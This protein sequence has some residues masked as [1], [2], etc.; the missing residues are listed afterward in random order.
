[1][2]AALFCF[3]GAAIA[4]AEEPTN[5][6]AKAQGSVASDVQSGFDIISSIDNAVQEKND[7]TIKV[8]NVNA[9]SAVLNW[10][11]SDLCISYR[12]CRFNIIQNKWED[13]LSTPKNELKLTNLKENTNYKYCVM[14]AATGE[15]LGVTEF[16]TGLSKPTIAV[17]ERD[18]DSVKLSVGKV[19]KGAKV[20]L[21]RKTKGKKYKKIATLSSKKKTYTDKKLKGA[22]TYYYKAKTT[23]T[24]K[25]NGKSVTKKSAYSKEKKAKTL[26]KMGLPAVSGKTKTYAIYTAVTVKSSPQYKLLHSKKCYTDKKT[27]VRMVDGCYC[28]ALGSY[29]GTKIGTKYRVTF[30]TGKQIDVI[31]C[32]Q[33]AD[34]HTDSRHQYAVGN[35]D[36]LEFYVEK[37]AMP[38]RARNL[39]N[40]GALDEFKGSVVAIEKYV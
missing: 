26:K 5:S 13:V 19:Q 18:G 11:G 23:V 16:T 33:K 1:M 22:T 15:L 8:S 40:Y 36:I 27:G 20:E 29:Y 17:T 25:V 12:I 32:D 4:H 38:R 30:S 21:Y 14:N 34:R 10:Y 3:S 7:F 28:V 31:L 39:G 35:S 37:S 9:N 24:G 6:Y 2:L